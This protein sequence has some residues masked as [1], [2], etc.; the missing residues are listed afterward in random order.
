MYL[1]IIIL[2]KARDLENILEKFREIEV[3]G[4]T[5]YNSI[6]VGRNTLYG[7]DLPMIASLRRIFDPD[8]KT[9]NKTLISVI[10]KKETLDSAIKLAQEVCGDFDEPDVG[11]MFWLNL[12]GVIGFN[13]SEH[14]N[15][16]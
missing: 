7:T 10:K 14:L 12:D 15:T 9:Y 4:A 13:V 11:I 6:G 8:E 5:V 3:T 1:L 16:D 2:D